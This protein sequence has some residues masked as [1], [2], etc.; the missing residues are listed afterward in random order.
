MIEF[1]GK[2]KYRKG[3]NVEDDGCIGNQETRKPRD[4]GTR[5]NGNSET[6]EQWNNGLFK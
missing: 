6:M 5:N 4:N 2:R 3:K 1:G